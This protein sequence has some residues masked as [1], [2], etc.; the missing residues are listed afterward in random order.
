M[1]QNILRLT[2]SA[3][4]VVAASGFA[5]WAGPLDAVVGVRAT[6]PSDARTAE[7]LEILDRVGAASPKAA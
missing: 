3:A 7:A 2:F 5:A 6:I 1:I 4:V